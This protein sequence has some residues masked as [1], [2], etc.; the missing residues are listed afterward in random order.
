ML[1]LILANLPLPL[2]VVLNI[3]VTWR[4]V[5][6]WRLEHGRRLGKPERLVT[7]WWINNSALIFAWVPAVI[8]RRIAVQSPWWLIS[9][10]IAA[11]LSIT[12][13][14]FMNSALEEEIEE[15]ATPVDATAVDTSRS[16]TL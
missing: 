16:D 6:V 8:E 7:G 2:I 4:F 10:A 13:L 15:L 14:L 5:Q 11:A 1:I 9:Y 3:R 12:G